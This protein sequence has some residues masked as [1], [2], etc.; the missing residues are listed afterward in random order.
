M[1]LYAV[2]GSHTVEACP[3][4]NLEIARKLVSFAELCCKG[5]RW[6][7]MATADRRNQSDD[8][9]DRQINLEE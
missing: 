9:R 7:N 5:T 8:R 1:S 6:V 4:N 2:Y 3:D